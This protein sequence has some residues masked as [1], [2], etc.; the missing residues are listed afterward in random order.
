MYEEYPALLQAALS[1]IAIID[2]DEWDALLA[3]ITF[4]T[5]AA[6]GVIFSCD[7]MPSKIY[8]VIEGI[9]RYFYI[10]RE[11]IERNKSLV[12]RGGAFASVST[13]AENLPSP[14]FAQAITPCTVGAIEYNTL[15]NLSESSLSLNRFLRK[16][17]ERLVLKKE[18]REAS[19]LL[20]SATERYHAFLS[21]FD[22]E[23]HLIP[24]R[25]VA[26][27]LGITDVTLSRIRK[28]MDLT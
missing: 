26:M 2:P 6:K 19:F 12:R 1:Q 14:F 21:E 13:I 18:K 11:G 10:D 15:V 9:G 5:Y 4:H 25:Q 28:E 16:L 17:F 20:M 22:G 8:F 23:S 7:D 27:Y 3:E 24:L